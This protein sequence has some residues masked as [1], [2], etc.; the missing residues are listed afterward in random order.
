M[1]NPAKIILT[2][3]ILFA[4][5]STSSIVSGP[6]TDSPGAPELGSGSRSKGTE[7]AA[8]YNTD[9]ENLTVVGDVFRTEF[10]NNLL[11]ETR[12]EFK[13]EGLHNS[14]QAWIEYTSWCTYPSS[15][16][17]VERLTQEVHS[18]NLPVG[19]V[20]GFH[21][22]EWQKLGIEE[23]WGFQY[24]YK[25]VL[26]ENKKWRYPNGT[27]AEDPHF[28]GD[29]RSFS[30]GLVWRLLDEDSSYTIMQTQNP[31][32]LTFLEEW[33][34]KNVDL[35]VDAL[36]LDSIDGSFPMFWN[37]GWGDN[38]TWE[39]LSF[40]QYLRSKHNQTEIANLGIKDLDGF[41]LRDYLRDKYKLVGVYGSNYTARD[42]YDLALGEHAIFEDPSRVMEDPV[43]KDY[44][45]FQY[46]GLGN[47]TETLVDNVKAYSRSRGKD[48]LITANHYMAWFPL[49]IPAPYYDVTYLENP[50]DRLPPYQR[51]SQI[52]KI[53]LAA[54]GFSKPV[55][56]AEWTLNNDPYGPNNS[57]AN[58]STL[59]KTQIAEG[60][61]SGCVR[62]IPFGVGSPEEGWP[63][64]RLM[65]GNEREPVA[66]YAQFL[67]AHEGLLKGAQSTA[68]VAVVLSVPTVIWDY[69]P[70]L[71]LY[72]DAHQSELNGWTRVLEEMHIPYDVLMF[73]M[74]P[75]FDDS[76][77]LA[78]LG[79]Y[80]LVIAP[81]LPRAS[82]E[83][84]QALTSHL[85]NGG[86]LL[87]TPSIGEKDEMNSWRD[88]SKLE[89]L[90]NSTQVSLVDY[91]LGSTYE[92]SAET[93]SPNMT[94]FTEMSTHVLRV[95]PLRDRVL[96]NASADT[97]ISTLVSASGENM[98]VHLVNYAYGFNSSTDWTTSQENV[99]VKVPLPEGYGASRVRLVSP[100]FADERL[101]E[102]N[103]TAG[104]AEFVVPSLNVWDIVVIDMVRTS[105]VGDINS[106]GR[107][108]MKD[109]SYV[110]RRF[111][112][113]PSDPLWAPVADIDNNGKID[114][115][116]ISTIARH[117]G[118]H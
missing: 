66:K 102:F 106:D 72:S 101:L 22:S 21:T 97:L 76:A 88:P 37:G 118:E 51:S 53:G 75:I 81:D 23:P 25:H 39:G 38:S 29:T 90:W 79:K 8:S 67:S 57:P 100:D 80:D 18:S 99:Y 36:F 50:T 94:A 3:T 54:N 91:G 47:F 109:V 70:T 84:I 43:V 69:F 63:P 95:L 15:W 65:T 103:S 98:T 108:D 28:A 9:W 61:A 92:R 27:I 114:M 68:K 7:V 14:V 32:W 24:Y 11:N 5:L 16:N 4:L 62:L 117:F 52:Y 58:I 41:C 1:K 46:T 48:V 115:K 60:F 82:D 93:K 105:L 26:A 73:G 111:M 116:D 17:G 20:F 56:M 40:I 96:T 31:F 71:G 74:Q 44:V 77:N 112:C 6:S 10:F 64:T 85:K 89:D 13:L 113:L 110:A 33:A 86:A 42:F 34:K 30:G 83:Q 12:D 49:I 45:L 2:T 19:S 107:I 104:Y 35:G 59:L 78:R 87:T 55:W